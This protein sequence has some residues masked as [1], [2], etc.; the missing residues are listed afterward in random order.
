MVEDPEQTDWLRTKAAQEV[1]EV[2]WQ[3]GQL[4]IEKGKTI[5]A[6]QYA[7]PWSTWGWWARRPATRA[8]PARP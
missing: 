3:P 8:G 5:T 7:R 1:P 4:I 2:W 6:D